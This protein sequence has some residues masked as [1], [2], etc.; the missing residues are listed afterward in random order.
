VSFVLGPQVPPA[1]QQAL[2]RLT[3]A[4][5]DFWLAVR[6]KL[7]PTPAKFHYVFSLSDIDRVMRTVLAV[8]PSTLSGGVGPGGVALRCGRRACCAAVR[9]TPPF[10]SPF[11][12]L[13]TP[14]GV[15]QLVRCE[16]CALSPSPL[17]HTRVDSHPRLP[18]PPAAR[19]RA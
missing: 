15:V 3:T 17:P 12:L 6:A 18:R 7:L 14:W 8:D 13:L 11:F 10:R 9:A 2:A 16:H 5:H 19:P 1:G 4:T